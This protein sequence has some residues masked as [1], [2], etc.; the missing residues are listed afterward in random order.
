MLAHS[1]GTYFP[2]LNAITPRSLVS[3]GSPS[4][5]DW[6]AYSASS[7]NNRLDKTMCS[8]PT[9]IRGKCDLSREVRVAFYDTN[10]W[11]TP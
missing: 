11:L 6:A 5:M 8:I 4:H 3:S 7:A 10:G 9:N 2:W 1:A